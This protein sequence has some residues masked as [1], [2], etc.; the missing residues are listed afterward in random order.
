MRGLLAGL[1]A[2]FALATGAAAKPLVVILAE[3][4]GTEITDAF[5]PYAILAESGAVEVKIVAPSAGPV[6][7]MPGVAWVA[8]QTTFAELARLRPD[9]PDVVIVPALRDEDDRAVL[10]WLR[11]QARG[12][13]RIMSIC[14][15][16]RVLAKTGLLDGREATV[17]WFSVGKMRKAHPKVAWRQD[18]RWVSDGPITTTAGIS[19]SAPASLNLLREL[20][21][22]PVMR[23]TAQRLGLPP[24]D[25]RHNGRDYHLTLR[26]MATVVLNRAAFW[27]REDVGVRITPGFDEMAFATTLDGWS[28]TYRSEGWAT[29][30]AATR[31]RHGLTVLRHQAPPAR[32]DR[33]VVPPVRNPTESTFGQIRTAYGELTARFVALQ[34]EHPWGAISAWP[35]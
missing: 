13:A 28:R 11:A 23:A 21:G 34:F 5:T 33:L 18:R 32:F 3:P 20:A 10:N 4:E 27:Q 14:N 12:G 1:A 9:G 25:P 15:G 24:P 16:A 29:G 30:P 6:R 19:A 31:S 22:E 17:H 7:L 26:G 35:T 2:A 8:P